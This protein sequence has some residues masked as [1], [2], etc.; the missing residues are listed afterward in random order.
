MLIFRTEC[1]T[2]TVYFSQR[3]AHLVERELLFD[4]HIAFA[5]PPSVANLAKLVDVCGTTPK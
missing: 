1:Q 4:A 2:A 5:F 3:Q